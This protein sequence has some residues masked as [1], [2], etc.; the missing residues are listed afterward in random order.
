M[1]P[2]TPHICEELWDRLGHS[3]SVHQQS[4]PIAD[5]VV[6]AAEE[7]TLVLQVN[8]KVRDKLTV[9]ADIS[10]EAA[11]ARALASENVQ[12]HLHGREPKN[13]IHVPGRLVNVVV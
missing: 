6:A 11:K 1:A 3:Y 13:V 4:W 5:A 8:G 2:V 12:R 10:D 9:P 7:I